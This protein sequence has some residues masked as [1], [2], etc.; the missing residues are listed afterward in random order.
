MST[1]YAGFNVSGDSKEIKRFKEKLF[2]SFDDEAQDYGP[3]CENSWD[4]IIDF[5]AICPKLTARRIALEQRCPAVY[6]PEHRGYDVDRTD[7]ED[8]SFWFQFTI[9]S[10][11]PA[12][13][14]EAIAVEFPTLLFSGSAYED[15]H[16]FEYAGE[17]NGDHP[18]CRSKLDWVIFE[19]QD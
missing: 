10:D 14:F 7:C 1:F 17:F 15:T 16:E 2:R 5:T 8:G 6:S 11:F 9:D 4:L 13:L 18:W 19:D 12:A 3:Y